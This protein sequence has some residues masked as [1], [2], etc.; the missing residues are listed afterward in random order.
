MLKCP[1]FQAPQSYLLGSHFSRISD[2]LPPPGPTI[3]DFYLPDADIHASGLC[4]F[5]IDFRQ[6]L[7][8][9]DYDIAPL[10]QKLLPGDHLTDSESDNEEE[11]H[12]TKPTVESISQI[13]HSDRYDK[14]SAPA[15]PGHDGN[16]AFSILDDAD[17]KVEQVEL[18]RDRKSLELSTHLRQLEESKI[19]MY[20]NRYLPL[21]PVLVSFLTLC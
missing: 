6:S 14:V 15:T 8:D 13:L 16:D 5:S 19:N 10:Q 11:Y 1:G 17:R 21:S 2:P 9:F 18:M 4:A 3:T 20:T 7:H 12:Q